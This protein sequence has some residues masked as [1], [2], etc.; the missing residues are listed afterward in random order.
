MTRLLVF[1]HGQKIMEADLSSK[2]QW[3]I[4][5]SVESDIVLDQDRGISRQ[6]LKLSLEKGKWIAE[7]L[8]RYGELYQKGKKIQTMH[9]FIMKEHISI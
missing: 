4:G 9:Y 6:H 7:V 8:S 2:S 5:R 1:H 3:V